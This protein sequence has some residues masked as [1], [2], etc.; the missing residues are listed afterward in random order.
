M[1]TQPLAQQLITSLH[2]GE[3]SRNRDFDRYTDAPGCLAYRHYRR[4]RS[5]LVEVSLPGCRAWLEPPSGEDDTALV[6]RVEG[7]LYRRRAQ[8]SRWEAAFFLG[9]M[10]GSRYLQDP[11]EVS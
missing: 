7:L 10:G 3:S 6:V 8:L 4:L 11:R 5:L 2:R 1:D 9:E